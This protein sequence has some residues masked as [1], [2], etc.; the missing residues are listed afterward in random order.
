[1]SCPPVG[2]GPRRGSNRKCKTIQ[3]SNS[4]VYTQKRRKFRRFLPIRPSSR[5]SNK[6]PGSCRGLYFI[7][8]QTNHAF[9]ERMKFHRITK[10]WLWLYTDADFEVSSDARHQSSLVLPD[11]YD[12]FNNQN[13][14]LD[15]SQYQNNY[16]SIA[17]SLSFRRAW[18][19]R[20]VEPEVQN[21]SNFK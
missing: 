10:L 7:S 3:K 1:M 12:G 9:S 15:Q 5:G 19:K 13:D 4:F 20:R 16:L 11:P 17:H 2:H 8:G 6:A 18:T 14:Y 21:Y